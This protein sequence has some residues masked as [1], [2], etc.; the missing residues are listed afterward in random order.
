MK[1]INL[2][3]FYYWYTQD[4]FLEVSDEVAAELHADKR[5]T[6][7][8]DQ[9]MR[10][11]KSYYSLDKGDCIEASA[12]SYFNDS[13]EHIFEKKEKH[14]VLCQALNSLPKIQGRRV[15][16]RFLLGKSVQEIAKAEGVTKG[17]VSISITRGL[18]AMKKYINNSDC[19]S[20]FCP[21]S[22]AGI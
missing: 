3:D 4:E 1:T 12:T 15:E 5:Y 11:N 17:S 14:C 19:L 9:R 20:N 2:K 22:E 13:P 8:H 16:A 21:Q 7:I 18:T 10:R 6:K